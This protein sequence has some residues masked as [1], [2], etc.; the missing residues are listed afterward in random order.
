MRDTGRPR[1]VRWGTLDKNEH[2]CYGCKDVESDSKEVECSDL[3]TPGWSHHSGQENHDSKLR[4]RDTDDTERGSNQ[5][6]FDSEKD[7][8]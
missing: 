3:I 6:P 8:F 5:D 4:H 7:A 1:S 2:R